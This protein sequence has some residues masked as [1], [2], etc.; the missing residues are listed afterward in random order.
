M[1]TLYYVPDSCS[2]ATHS[3]LK[4]LGQTPQLKAAAA[5]PDYAA[6]NPTQLVPTLA[7]KE[8][9]LT[10][11]AAII[12]YLLGNHPNDLLPV[13]GQAR[14][15]VIEHLMLANASMHPAYSR[16]FFAATH[17][18][19]ETAKAAFFDAASQSINQLWQ[20]I[21]NKISSGPYLRG[22]EVSPADV[23][24]AVYSRWGQAF[25]VDILIG[26]K[27]QRMIDHVLSSAA[28]KAALEEQ[29]DDAERVNG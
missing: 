26:P 23:L 5:L 8:L 13:A 27:A 9:R 17:I 10:E 19:D 3:I 20:V 12:L 2:L 14:Q 11:G 7:V 28:F 18:Q 6:I 25:P 4:M 16:L 21:E 22:A 1:Y 15:T 29:N 24:L